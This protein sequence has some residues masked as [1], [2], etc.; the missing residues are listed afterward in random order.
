MLHK[1][2]AGALSFLAANTTNISPLPEVSATKL[3]GPDHLD[4]FS[5]VSWRLE[6]EITTLIEP[7]DARKHLFQSDKTYWLVGLAGDLGQSLCDWMADHGARFIVLMSR[8]RRVEEPWIKKHKTNGV[9][10][11]FMAG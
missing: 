9:T 1:V 3:S 2:S 8:T 11:S 6:T 10:V 4:P 5:V 7:V